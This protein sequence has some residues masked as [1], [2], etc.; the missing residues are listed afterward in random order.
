MGNRLLSID[1]DL[2]TPPS[3]PSCFRDVTLQASIR[4]YD[5]V[6]ISPLDWI[7]AYDNWFAA[8]GLWD[9]VAAILTPE[10]AERESFAVQIASTPN[11]RL[12]VINLGHVLRLL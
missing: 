12:T 3:S 6:A 8:Y 9:Y 11:G 10:E 1:A 4:D 7:D 5:T 2:S